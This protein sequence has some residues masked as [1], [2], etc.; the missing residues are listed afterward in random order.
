M[1]LLAQAYSKECAQTGSPA[2][3]AAL[4][5]G[6]AELVLPGVV[7]WV[8]LSVRSQDALS[9]PIAAGLRR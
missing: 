5:S 7:K 6:A 8:P 4:M 2:S 3:I 9:Q 1:S